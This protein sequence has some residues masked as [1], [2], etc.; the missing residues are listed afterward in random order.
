[1]TEPPT[2]LPGNVEVLLWSMTARRTR[3]LE[4]ADDQRAADRVVFLPGTRFTVLE[5]TPPQH[6]RPGR[7]LLRELDAEEPLRRRSRFDDLALTSLLRCHERWT[8]T[9]RRTRVGSAA[10]PR[11]LH[12]PGIV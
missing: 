4:P 7:L 5:A 11:F 2:N 10:V 1:M 9:G 8:A 6:D 12:L 3:L